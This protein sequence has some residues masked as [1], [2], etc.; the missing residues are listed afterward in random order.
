M[1][2]ADDT[3][4]R[5][6]PPVKHEGTRLQYWEVVDVIEG[7]VDGSFKTAVISDRGC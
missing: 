7:M 3:V 5:V 6:L 1:P 4:P 2:E